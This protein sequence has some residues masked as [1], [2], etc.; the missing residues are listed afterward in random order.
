MFFFVNQVD[1]YM[2]KCVRKTYKHE[3]YVVLGIFFLKHFIV[4]SFNFEKKNS[5]KTLKEIFGVKLY[6]PSQFLFLSHPFIF[7]FFLLHRM[8]LEAHKII[9]C[10][11]PNRFL[12]SCFMYLCIFLQLI[13]ISF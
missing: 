12:F 6:I 5:S 4:S 1:I 8:S 3:C 2:V 10:G 7:L 9:H 13:V 11:S